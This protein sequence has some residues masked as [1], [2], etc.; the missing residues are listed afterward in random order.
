MSMVIGTGQLL[1]HMIR[2]RLTQKPDILGD[3]FVARESRAS[4]SSPL[5]GDS[6]PTIHHQRVCCFRDDKR[7]NRRPAFQSTKHYCEPTTEQEYDARCDVMEQ[8]IV[9]KMKKDT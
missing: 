1:F 5:I 3:A 6:P 7:G 8:M 2:R 9:D 4:V